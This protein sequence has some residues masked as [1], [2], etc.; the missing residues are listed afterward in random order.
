MKDQLFFGIDVLQNRTIEHDDAVMFDI[1]DTLIYQL[2]GS[3]GQPMVPMI[4]LIREA[5]A[6]GYKIVII[7]ARPHY[8]ENVQITKMQLHALDIPY[9]YL[10]FAPAEQ[11]GIVKQQIGLKFILSVGDMPT[12]L[13]HSVYYI[14][15]MTGKYGA[16]TSN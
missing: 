3:T 5:D 13:T 16:N 4:E 1:D 14:N 12:D 6:L 11:K 8:E 9:D 7:T 2:L 15:T 10:I